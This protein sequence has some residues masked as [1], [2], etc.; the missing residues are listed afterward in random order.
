MNILIF[1]GTTEGRVLSGLLSEKRKNEDR[2]TVSVASDYGA[3][4]LDD[5]PGINIH[6]GRMDREGMTGY[7]R[8]EGFDMVVDATHPFA[9]EATANISAACDSCGVRYLRLRREEEADEEERG[10]VY[11]CDSCDEAAALLEKVNDSRAKQ[12]SGKVNDPQG[13]NILLT[14]GS[15]ELTCFTSRIC[16]SRL[17]ARVIPSEESVEKCRAA[18]LEESHIIAEMGPFS[19]DANVRHIRDH[20][21]GCLVTKESGEGSGYAEKRKAAADNG[22]ICIVIKRR[23][24]GGNSMSEILNA[25]LGNI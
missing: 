1:G 8:N 7:I 18:G 2:I 19:Y 9:V 14:T 15:K 22:V 12:F 4:M 11:Y 20:G 16:P 10:M 21:I 24:H 6:V 5:I 17:F 23:D 25:I 3:K 13:R